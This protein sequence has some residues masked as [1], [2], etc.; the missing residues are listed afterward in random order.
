[1]ASTLRGKLS[2]K[3]LPTVLP[4]KLFPLSNKFEKSGRGVSGHT[5][6]QG[7]GLY[8]TPWLCTEEE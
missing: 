2:T 3:L 8:A 7:N 4:L 5:W 6:V 1:M